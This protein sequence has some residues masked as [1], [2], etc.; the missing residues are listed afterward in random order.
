MFEELLTNEPAKQALAYLN[1][2]NHIEELS[3]GII[4][5][6]RLIYYLSSSVFFLFLASRAL[7]DKKWR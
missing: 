7:A 6:R 5:T 4:D 2:W 3:K 1:F